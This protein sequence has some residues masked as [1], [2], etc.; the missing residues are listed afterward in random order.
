MTARSLNRRSFC[1]LTSAELALLTNCLWTAN[2]PRSGSLIIDN[3][4]AMPHTVEV[5]LS[6]PLREDET[7]SPPT[8]SNSSLRTR[9][10]SYEVTATSQRTLHD[11]ITDPGQYTL[12]AR[13]DN[14]ERDSGQQNL[15]RGGKHGTKI[16][17]GIF[18]IEIL[19]TGRVVVQ[20]PDQ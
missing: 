9:T 18:I 13:L 10:E 19:S 11:F 12:E 5:T 3:R 14:G 17:G 6:R 15:Y 2:A 20:T 7:P 8:T 4:H 16:G 1:T